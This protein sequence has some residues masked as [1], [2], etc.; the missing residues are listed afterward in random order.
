MTC[1]STFQLEQREH[2]TKADDVLHEIYEEFIELNEK[3][4]LR[5][6]R[7]VDGVVSEAIKALKKIDPLFKVLFK[8]S[9]SY[10]EIQTVQGS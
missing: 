3:E 7:I 1:L 5:S 8:V 2:S 10:D 6:K 9:I 4:I